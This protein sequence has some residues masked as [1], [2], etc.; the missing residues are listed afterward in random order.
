MPQKQI[1]KEAAWRQYCPLETAIV[2]CFS[3]AQ[4]QLS[5][6]EAPLLLLV[7]LHVSPPA[8]YP[9]INHS[10]VKPQDVNPFIGTLILDK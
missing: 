1:R 2:A 7:S 9:P 3:A 10:C 6:T 4:P 8:A 5:H